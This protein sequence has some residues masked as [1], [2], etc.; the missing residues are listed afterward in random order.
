MEEVGSFQLTGGNQDSEAGEI[1]KAL[2]KRAFVVLIHS[3]L[4][5]LFLKINL[6][7]RLVGFQIWT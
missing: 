6:F 4:Q 5:Q 2:L 1:I 7:E 3:F